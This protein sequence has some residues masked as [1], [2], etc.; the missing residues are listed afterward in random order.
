LFH[1]Q[2]KQNTM[3]KVYFISTIVTM[4][5]LVISL[6]GIVTAYD[7]LTYVYMF[8]IVAVFCMI[9]LFKYEKLVRKTQENL[10]D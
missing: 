7:T 6:A 9:S 1:N 3:K 4:V 2:I 10:V 5:L 8:N